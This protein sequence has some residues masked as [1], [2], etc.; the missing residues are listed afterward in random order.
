[1]PDLVVYTSLSFTSTSRCVSRLG[2]LF[3]MYAQSV[4][5]QAHTKKTLAQIFYIDL[6][7]KD[8]DF[9]SLDTQ[10]SLQNYLLFNAHICLNPDK[11]LEN[12]NLLHRIYVHCE[13]F[14]IVFF[15]LLS[16]HFILRLIMSFISCSDGFKTHTILS[17]KRERK[18]FQINVSVFLSSKRKSLGARDKK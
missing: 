11:Q 10:P 7:A 18:Y 17:Q 6:T 9:I 13:S 5:F 14:L 15:L 1:M 8:D 16:C 3:I 12:M 2:A 4:I